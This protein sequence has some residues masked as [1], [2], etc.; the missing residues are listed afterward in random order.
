MNRVA[1]ELPNNPLIAERESMMTPEEQ[2]AASRRLH[3]MGVLELHALS[4]GSEVAFVGD[5]TR[6]T[7]KE[8]RAQ[9]ASVA[10]ELQKRGIERGDRVVILGLNSVDYVIALLAISAVGGV[11][12]PLNSRSVP[13]ELDYF[14]TDSGAK[15]G[16][17]DEMGVQVFAKAEKASQL[18]LIRFGEEFAQ[19]ANAEAEPTFVDVDEN[20]ESFIIY[21]SGTTSAPKGVV[22]T[23]MNM[24]SQALNTTR[25]SPA[26]TMNDC[27]MIVVPLFHIAGIGFLYPGI[28]HGQRTVIAPP[29]ALMQ[30]STLVDLAEAERVTNLFLV[31]TLWQAL[32]SL[33]GIRD[34][35]LSLRGLSWGASPASRETLQ[36]MAD[37]FPDASIMAAFGQTEMSPTTCNL[38]GDESVR[39]MGSVGKPIGLVAAKVVDPLGED[40]PPGEPGE[41]VYRGP[42]LMTRYWN[43]PEQTAEAL[44]GGWFHSGD[45]VREDD[46]GF[47]FVV[48]RAKDIIISGRENISSVEVEQA[49][50]AHPKVTDASVIGVPDPKWVE[51]PMAVIV[52]ADAED[53][54]SLEEIREFLSDRLASFKKPTRLEVVDVLPRNASGKLQKHKLRQDFVVEV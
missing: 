45:L 41:I 19:I 47:M 46:D 16:F 43:K 44:A 15:V 28:L 36:L 33:P 38:P 35:K 14:V 23:H 26:A 11:A 2:L 17:A 5:G 25:V 3:W 50:A 9:T 24:I 31:P 39:K 7:W 27:G 49:V 37:T 10:T 12:C 40:V 53:V 6:L 22:L 8:A 51:T 20:D 32:C 54:P 48:D 1:S 29:Q 13:A 18:P 42:G 21:T 52:P 4:R 34:R 30:I